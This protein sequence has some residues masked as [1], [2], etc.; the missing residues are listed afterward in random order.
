MASELH[1]LDL[2][3]N[4]AGQVSV[5]VLL[6]AVLSAV[7]QTTSKLRKSAKIPL[8]CLVIGGNQGGFDVEAVIK[9]IHALR[10]DIDIARDKKGRS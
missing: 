2:S 5:V 6:K 8:K 10:P 4:N 3:G 7:E 1:T 9:Q